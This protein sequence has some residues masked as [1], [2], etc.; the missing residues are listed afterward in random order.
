MPSIW[1]RAQLETAAPS[2]F[3][4]ETRAGGAV[5]LCLFARVTFSKAHGLFDGFGSYTQYRAF[6]GLPSVERR[7]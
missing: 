3:E 7:I 1:L 2:V 4:K 6:T 5:C